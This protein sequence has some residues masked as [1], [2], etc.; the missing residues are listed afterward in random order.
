MREGVVH[1]RD[2]RVARTSASRADIGGCIM[3]TIVSR[4]GSYMIVVSY[5]IVADYGSAPPIRVA[6]SS[7]TPSTPVQTTA[8]LRAELYPASHIP[9]S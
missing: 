4:S 2:I 9:P 1:N 7:L 5:G 8:C 6:C 3:P